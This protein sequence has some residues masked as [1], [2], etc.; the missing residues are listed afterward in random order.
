MTAEQASDGDLLR[1][2]DRLRAALVEIEA[3]LPACS[4]QSSLA[5]DGTWRCFARELQRVARVA[6]KGI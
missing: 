5:T 1:E 3:G 2:R 6:L 4:A